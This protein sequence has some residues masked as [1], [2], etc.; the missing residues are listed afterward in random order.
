[1]SW[2]TPALM[3]AIFSSALLALIYLFIYQQ[4]KENFLLIWT[5]SWTTYF[6]H[7]L[8][9]LFLLYFPNLEPV[10]I[11]NQ[12]LSLLSG[13]LLIWGTHIFA[14]KDIHKG[15]KVIFSLGFLW[16]LVCIPLK[17]S[18]T[19]LTFPTFTILSAVYIWTGYVL[20]KTTQ[21][22]KTRLLPALV[23][24]IW[25]ILKAGYPFFRPVTWFA[26][27]GYWL[28]SSLSIFIAISILL[29]YFNAAKRE[30]QESENR[31]KRLANNAPD[32]LYRAQ[33]LPEFRLEYVSPAITKITGYTPEEFCLPET[34]REVI[35]DPREHLAQMQINLMKINQNAPI[36]MRWRNKDGSVIFLEHHNSPVFNDRGEII[37]IEGIARD[38][39]E[40]KATERELQDSEEKY[41]L[42][43]KNAHEGIFIIQNNRFQFFNDKL[44]EITSYDKDEI[45]KNSFYQPG[46][47]GRQR[48]GP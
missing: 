44:L 28:N 6:L 25:G 37:S 26:F 33:I 24:I 23:F 42:V 30:L 10:F 38:I 18:F 40:R 39:T 32:I 16:I 12:I 34:L 21:Y 15:W 46:P 17:L 41:R 20:L 11:L 22:D 35:P 1:M 2:L 29:I 9:E 27:W 47:S 14:K 31:Y 43:I 36:I 8:L 45:G 13:I 48:L 5:A 3:T 19:L 4:D 7:L